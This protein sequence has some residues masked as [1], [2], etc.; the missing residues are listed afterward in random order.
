MN[1]PT[2]IESIDD[3]TRA[4]FEY[5]TLFALDVYENVRRV[6]SN[7][8]FSFYSIPMEADMTQRISNNKAIDA[9]ARTLVEGNTAFALDLYQQLRQEEGNLFF[10]PYSISTALAMTY[11]GAR[12]KTEAEMALVLYF[13][14][15]Q[16]KLH[17][18]FAALETHFAQ[19]QEKG[20]IAIYVANSLWPQIGYDFLQAFLDL[21][22][23][24]YGVAITAVNYA[25]DPQR[26]RQQINAWVEEKTRDKIKELLKP[27]HV[28][29]LTTLA[30]VNAIYF[31]GNWSNSFDK[32]ETRDNIFCLNAQ[33]TVKVSMMEQKARF[34]YAVTDTLQVLEMPYVGGDLSMIVLLPQEKTGLP[35]LEDSLSVD[36]IGEWTR[37]LRQMK[38]R[39]FLPRFKLTGEFDLSKTLKAMGMIAAFGDA[40]FSGMTG[41][42]DLFISEVV[43]K[44]F[45][46]VNEEGTE[47]AAATAVVMSRGVEAAPLFYA[48]HPFIFLIRENSTGS[49]LFLGRVVDPTDPET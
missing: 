4:L 38:V 19:I 46:D 27:H 17:P 44:A 3:S 15:G 11:G 30:L 18:A 31:K 12:G 35:D 16:G 25:G 36:A 6:K 21:C 45:V 37:Q 28:T 34:G 29:P 8:S 10:S 49:L 24:Y 43:H 48:D 5:D 41:Q 13:D 32:A 40:D 20:D 23:R 14:L 7:E 9:D 33:D 42:R 2:S 47:A 26:A 1:Q 22:S 39:V